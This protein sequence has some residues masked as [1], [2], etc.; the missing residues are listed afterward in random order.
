MSC[1][2]RWESSLQLLVV[3][4]SARVGGGLSYVT[5]QVTALTTVRPDWAVELLAA[6]W[7]ADALRGITGTTITTVRLRGTADRVAYEQVMLPI[8]G[9]TADAI[10]CPGN[11]VPF[12]AT[13]PLIVAQQ[14]PHYFGRGRELS[15]TLGLRLR[16]ERWFAVRSMRRA[17]TVVVISGSLAAEIAA[18]GLAAPDQVL[19][20]SG[21]PAVAEGSA[22]PPG[23]DG[24]ATF[25]LTLANDSP[26]KRL[27]DAVRAWGALDAPAPRLVLAGRTTEATIARHGTLVP[28][29]RAEGLIHLGP[30]R[31]PREVRWLLERALALIVPSELEAFPLTPAEAGAVGCPL[32][33]S[34]IPPHREVTGGRGD[35]VAVGDVAGFT[36]AMASRAA[37][38]P[39]REP[40]TWPLSWEDNAEQLATAIEAASG[41]R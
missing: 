33:L 36:R 22:R 3:A 18:D 37:T 29:S 32:I 30:V 23:V 34:D 41:S 7:N 12:A 17:D 11:F 10:Y 31:D 15:R 2:R 40:W 4:L 6:P 14:N 24:E 21:A 19:I 35:Y 39:D 1:D 9:R 5:R 26:H 8:K 38:P 27:D 13:R 20:R 16:F 25:F 28:R